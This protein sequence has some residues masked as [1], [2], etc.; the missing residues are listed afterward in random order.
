MKNQKERYRVTRDGIM[1]VKKMQD[2]EFCGISVMHGSR[3]VWYR[4]SEKKPEK[5]FMAMVFG[6]WFGLHKFLEKKY[7]Q[8]IFYLLTCGCFGVFYFFDLFAMLAGDYSCRKVSYTEDG[9]R[10]RRNTQKIYYKPLEDK[11]KC[12]LLLFPAMGILALALLLIYQPA[13]TF[14]LEGVLS[15]VIDTVV[16]QMGKEWSL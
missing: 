9:R 5:Q 1:L 6:G 3:E 7:W 16:Q 4:C 14:L 13:G 12:F 2:Y 8:G 15:E 10:I 11:K